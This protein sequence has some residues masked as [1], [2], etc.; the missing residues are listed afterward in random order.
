MQKIY[1][2]VKEINDTT[3]LINSLIYQK[4]NELL[5]ENITSAQDL[6]LTIIHQHTNLTIR[7]IAE[8]L[9]ITPSAT[10]QQVSKLANL[11]YVNREINE[12]NRREI[13]VTLSH[14][15]IAYIEKQA[16][17][18]QIITEKLYA[19]I[20]EEKLIVFRDILLDL[21]QITEDECK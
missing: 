13:L 10:S 9:K 20:G 21:K 2:L 5:D 15:G 7:E 4:Y 6:L 1:E 18:D 14:K 12:K 3:H 17:V 16:K 8:K 11:N 19:K